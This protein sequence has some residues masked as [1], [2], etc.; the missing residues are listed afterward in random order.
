M[1]ATN[2]PTWPGCVVCQ[3]YS[4]AVKQAHH[5]IHIFESFLQQQFNFRPLEQYPRSL[6]EP[7]HVHRVI[8]NFAM[9]GYHN[10][11]DDVKP[12]HRVERYLHFPSCFADN[13]HCY[14]P[15]EAALYNPVAT[16][17]VALPP[18]VCPQH[19]DDAKMEKADSPFSRAY[20]L[21]PIGGNGFD[22]PT[23][24]AVRTHVDPAQYETVHR[25]D[26]N[27]ARICAEDE[28]EELASPSTVESPGARTPG[29]ND[30]DCA[31]PRQDCMPTNSLATS[32]GSNMS[33][34]FTGYRNDLFGV[35]GHATSIHGPQAQPRY[36]SA[37]DY[38]GLG[39]SG[40]PSVP[41][42]LGA[43]HSN[44]APAVAPAEIF[45]HPSIM[46]ASSFADSHRG[47][48]SSDGDLPSRSEGVSES[49]K[50]SQKDQQLVELR[51]QGKSYKQIKSLTGWSEAESTL[52]GRM[53]VLTKPK[54]DRVRK[55]E[56]EVRDVSGNPSPRSVSYTD[57]Y[58]HRSS[59][60]AEPS[61]SM[62]EMEEICRGRK[63]PSG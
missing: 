4:L 59:S 30:L 10:L 38:S 26:W 22:M 21:S 25:D 3:R 52:R 32:F 36:V 58:F 40:L 37:P 20:T 43:I 51:N 53:R 2:Q 56:W 16:G 19:Q 57:V 5:R 13:F 23:T 41:T 9:D 15:E 24:G 33:D 49:T 48:F 8:T 29:F 17:L 12:P 47:S 31:A 39:I 55:P 14:R 6:P 62:T 7:R 44:P 61:T 63:C 34:M 46:S 18:M 1:Q 60:F 54:Q 45:R 11:L 42:T 35:G 50:R 28:E 27:L